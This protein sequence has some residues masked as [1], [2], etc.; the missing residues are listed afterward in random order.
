MG[1]FNSTSINILSEIYLI[2]FFIRFQVSG[3]VHQDLPPEMC[4]MN[5]I[6]FLKKITT[7]VITSWLFVLILI[8]LWTS[9]ICRLNFVFYFRVCSRS[10]TMESTSSSCWVCWKASLCL[11]TS[12]TS[13]RRIK[14]KR[15]KGFRCRWEL[16]A[17]QDGDGTWGTRKNVSPYF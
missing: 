12:F 5:L 9:K 7:W 8:S 15:W 16:I 3:V 13:H 11:S 1:T 14:T 2:H 17:N 4:R 6:H 10:F